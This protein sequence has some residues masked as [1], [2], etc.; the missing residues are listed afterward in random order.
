MVKLGEVDD[1]HRSIITLLGKQTL[2]KGLYIVV[3]VM[4]TLMAKLAAT[5]APIVFANLDW[6]SVFNK[7]PVAQTKQLRWTTLNQTM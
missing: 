7:G 1:C 5:P 6:N 3:K 4:A 2:V